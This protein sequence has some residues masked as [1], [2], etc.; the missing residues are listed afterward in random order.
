MSILLTSSALIVSLYQTFLI[1][2]HTYLVI[3]ESGLGRVLF[4]NKRKYIWYTNGWAIIIV[5]LS[6]YYHPLRI[7]TDCS[8]EEVT[9]DNLYVIFCIITIPEFVYMV[10]TLVFYCLVMCSLKGRYLNSSI[11]KFLTA[12]FKTNAKHIWNQ[13]SQS[14]YYL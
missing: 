2:L 11:W 12:F 13:W 9:S 7:G 10:L 8:F 6:F 14:A 5:P 1:G 4:K 3:T